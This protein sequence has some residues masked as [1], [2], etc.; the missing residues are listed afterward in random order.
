MTSHIDIIK[1]V[2]AAFQKQDIGHIISQFAVGPISW[3][4]NAANTGSSVPW[5]FSASKREDIPNFFKSLVHMDLQVFEI[6]D[7]AASNDR[8]YSLLHMEYTIKKNQ[9]KFVGDGLHVFRFNDKNEIVEHTI[10]AD[11]GRE[12]ALWNSS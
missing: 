3:K 4:T 12:I 2:Y 1:G 7:L 6:K 5:H 10:F 9:K 8:V 11:D